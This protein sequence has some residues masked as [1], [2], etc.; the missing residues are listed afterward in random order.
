MSPEQRREVRRL[1]ELISEIHGPDRDRAIFRVEDSEVRAEV[2]R[3]LKS[4][5]GTA[6][7]TGP[8]IPTFFRP[9]A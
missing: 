9:A 5:S 4:D 6:T 2:V 3:L 7:A 1:F 8:S